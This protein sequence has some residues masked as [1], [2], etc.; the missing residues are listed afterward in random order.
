MALLADI[1]SELESLLAPIAGDSPAGVNLDGTLELSALELAAAE[2]E[3]AVVAG[4]ERSD[5]RNWRDIR[6]QAQALLA[7]SKD[8]RVAVP[9]VRALLQ[10]E[11]LPGF[12]AGVGFICSLTERYWDVLHPSLDPEE[13]DAIMRSNALRELVSGPFLAE[14][15]VAPMF[16]SD[17]RLKATANDLLLA[18]GNP[19]AKPELPQTPSHIV[20]AALDA[21]GPAV[22]REHVD[23]LG[24]TRSRLAALLDGVFQKTGSRPQLAALV[25]SEPRG[26]PGLL[27]A[28][29]QSLSDEAARLA[30]TNP[31]LPDIANEGE[32]G[33]EPNASQGHAGQPRGTA[34]HASPRG[35]AD[36][37]RREDVIMMI[38][39]ICAYYT[40][41]EPSSPV[42]LLLR[43]AKRLVTM[44][45]LEIVRDLADQ[46]LPQVG[47][48][49]GIP[50][51]DLAGAA[52]EEERY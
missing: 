5:G 1:S 49:A 21:L 28:L 17:R 36:I 40:R 47:N 20:F 33:T 30:S 23:L 18:T 41:V 6:G 9:L 44:D 19:L 25:R 37:S 50:I 34:P 24:N 11:G 10:L 8:L 27:D 52:I 15:R 43:R 22:L 51:P 38:E 46:G 29:H 4:V 12:C 13:G 3:D 31:A 35:T 32:H 26:A 16:G 39:R 2:P 7:R 48:V 45:F 14:L 42:P